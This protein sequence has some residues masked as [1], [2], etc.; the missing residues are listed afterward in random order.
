L[1]EPESERVVEEKLRVE[2][3]L[4]EEAVAV[5]VRRRVEDRV[6]EDELRRFGRLWAIT[7]DISSLNS[8]T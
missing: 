1:F 4:V 5:A 6:D 3:E 2:V 7:I 8:F